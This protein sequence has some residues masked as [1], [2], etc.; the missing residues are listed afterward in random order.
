MHLKSKVIVL[1][2]IGA[3]VAGLLAV[4][5]GRSAPTATAF[6][7]SSSSSDSSSALDL[8]AAAG[9][10]AVLGRLWFD[11]M[12]ASP[13][14]EENTWLFLAGGLALQFSGSEYRSTIELFD[15]ERAKN[16]LELVTLQDDTT[17]RVTFEVKACDEKPP[18]NLCLR[19]SEPLR[20]NRVLYGFGSED[21]AASRY[22]WFRDLRARARSEGEAFAASQ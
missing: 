17:I 3:L 16:R 1:C 21:E 15:L 6:P 11:R 5:R 12:P 10:R 13:R 14:D 4:A 2:V 20:G 22:G 7:S 8:D 19:F 9:G 18:F